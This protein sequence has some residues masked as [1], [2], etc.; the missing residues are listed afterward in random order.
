MKLE[1]RKESIIPIILMLSVVVVWI[2]LVIR[3]NSD[4]QRVVISLF[5]FMCI[6]IIPRGIPK[7]QKREAKC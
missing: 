3:Y 4:I 1:M 2:F 5:A 6:L 7:Q